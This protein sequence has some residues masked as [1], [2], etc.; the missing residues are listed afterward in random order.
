MSSPSPPS[1]K[2]RALPLSLLLLV[3]LQLL[4]YPG[5]NEPHFD[6]NIL[7]SR[8]R[9]LKERTQSMEDICYFLVEK[10]E[11]GRAGAK[12]VLPTYPCSKPSDSMGFR[13]SLAKYI[14]SVR[15]Q[16]LQPSGSSSSSAAVVSGSSNANAKTSGSGKPGIARESRRGVSASVT[17]NA[18]SAASA[19][20]AAYWWKD[21]IVRKSLLDECTGER[22]LKM[23]LALSTHAVSK[24][25]RRIDVANI[26]GRAESQPVLYET[27]LS[28][29]Q[30]ARSRWT[31]AAKALVLKEERL[32][33][34]KVQMSTSSQPSK[35]ASTSTKRLL[36]FRDS[37]LV[38]ITPYWKGKDGQIALQML[39][40]LA[41]FDA[42][43]FSSASSH[44]LNDISKLDGDK[45]EE[46]PS[47]PPPSLL[48]AA[49]HHPAHLKRLSRSVFA[50]KKAKPRSK[51]TN[52]EPT[53]S[54]AASTSPT[55]AHSTAEMAL[56]SHLRV[57]QRMQ[58]SPR[59]CL[60]RLEIAYGRLER[61]ISSL[62][63]RKAREKKLATQESK[64]ELSLKLKLWEVGAGE[65][66][67]INFKP[68][69]PLDFSK[70]SKLSCCLTDV[71]Q[72]DSS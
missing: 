8:V 33:S 70:S 11:G 27:R 43:E 30:S 47:K 9:G 48:V 23:I 15:M 28:S 58:V 66:F 60:T 41:G 24:K 51:A 53:P 64:A 7:E 10:L 36:A 61:K 16:A 38:D 69:V 45:T 1:H 21:V 40:G 46:T 71:S 25:S 59:D 44:G 42:Q 20:V 26:T 49:A 55:S 31:S 65:I 19:S 18:T 39:L 68:Q 29:A 63:E 17:S 6:I 37:R 4:Q 3:H 62:G 54:L 35:F 57:E 67:R 12:K 50:E 72:S 56:S 14:D 2:L 22:F 52:S 34:L 5:V 32:R 13:T